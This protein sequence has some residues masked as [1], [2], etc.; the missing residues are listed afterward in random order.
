MIEITAHL[1]SMVVIVLNY[2]DE[3]T[4]QMIFFLENNYIEQMCLIYTQTAVYV[5]ALIV[6][7]VNLFSTLTHPTPN[8]QLC[9]HHR[10]ALLNIYFFFN[11]P[12]NFLLLELNGDFIG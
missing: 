11:A 10:K 12:L 2:L 7:L 4:F 9:Q 8:W 6:N 5:M 1:S 3:F